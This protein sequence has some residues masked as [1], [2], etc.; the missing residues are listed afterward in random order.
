MRRAIPLT[1]QELDV[2]R[3][4]IGRFFKRQRGGIPMID[5]AVAVERHWNYHTKKK[6]IYYL[7][8]QSAT[9]S[10]GFLVG[11]KEELDSKWKEVVGPEALEEI[12]KK[13][14]LLY[15]RRRKNWDV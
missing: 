6:D 1:Q 8:I 3:S 7:Y 15:D 11:S 13:I 10:S 12:A 14:Q 5:M 2:L 9:T 4:K